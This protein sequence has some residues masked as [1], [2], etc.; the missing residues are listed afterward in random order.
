MSFTPFLGSPIEQT[1]QSKT[2]P[3]EPDP[4]SG[5]APYLPTKVGEDEL[6]NFLREDVPE[7]PPQSWT[8]PFGWRPGKTK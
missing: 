8:A 4:K 7:L 2:P 1:T 3:A 6:P 5:F